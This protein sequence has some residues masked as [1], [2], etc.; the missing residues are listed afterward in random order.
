MAGVSERTAETHIKIL[1]ERQLLTLTENRR[2]DNSRTANQ[3][4][5][6]IHSWAG[7]GFKPGGAADAPGG[8]A[9]D[10]PGGAAGAEEEPGKE[11]GNTELGKEQAKRA[12]I[13]YSEE[14]KT[15]LLEVYKD[16]P[17]AAFQI[18]LAMQHVASKK[19]PDKNLY[20]RNWLNRQRNGQQTGAQR[21]PVKTGTTFKGYG[22]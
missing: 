7:A 21:Q 22:E 8:G 10:A 2:S 6:T 14:L 18:D 12:P 11:P 19:N 17:D 9:A 1:V 16:V 20:L 13:P 4:N 5:L 15:V 3:Y